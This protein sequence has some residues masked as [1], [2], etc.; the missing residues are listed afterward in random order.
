MRI[1]LWFILSLYSGLVLLRNN[2]MLPSSKYLLQ[3]NLLPG[4]LALLRRH[5]LLPA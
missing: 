3:H 1:C 5:K 2:R 4:G